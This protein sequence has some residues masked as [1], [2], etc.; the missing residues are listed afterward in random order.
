MFGLLLYI[1]I[2]NTLLYTLVWIAGIFVFILLVIA[3]LVQRRIR[4]RLQGELALQEQVRQGY[5]EYEFILKAMKLCVWHLNPKTRIITHEMDF[6]E[7]QDS[8]HVMPN[9]PIETIVAMMVKSARERVYSALVDICTGRTS[10]FYQQYQIRPRN[11]GPLLWEESYA[12]VV[13]RD[14]EGFPEKIVGASMYIGERKNMEAALVNARN[15]AEESER[16]KTAFL[17]NIG[18]E[19]RTPLNAIVGFADL[20]SLVEGKEER[21]QL[22]AEIQANNQK[23]IQV[24][25]GLVS[26]SQVEAESKTLA[27]S[28]V[29]LNQIITQMVGTYA[30]MVHSP[31]VS[32][33]TQFPRTELTMVTD[34]DKLTEILKHIMQNAVKFTAKG[35][36]T[37]G[38][39]YLDEDDVRIWIRDTG[40]GIPAEEQERIFDRFVKLDD[41]VPGM[42]L[43]LSA[44]K[45]YVDSLGG[46]IGVE[47]RLGEGSTFWVRLPLIMT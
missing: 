13:A 42:G 24:V 46:V 10:T 44:T 38:Y 45:S 6:R 17:A 36:I 20:L 23:L 9:G 19:I 32:I 29:D 35:K 39:D 12:T 28:Q 30:M 33:E 18:H 15:K 7:R 2:E 3:L 14:A 34:L 8:H 41:F 40:K 21:D 31:D 47:S 5:V 22:I 26:M 11:T 27:Y 43:G 1:H 37:V 25:E 4:A 16:M